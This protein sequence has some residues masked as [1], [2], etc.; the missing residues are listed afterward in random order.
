MTLGVFKDAILMKCETRG[1]QLGL[2]I[3]T[4]LFFTATL[5]IAYWMFGIAEAARHTLPEF[6]QRNNHG[7]YQNWRQRND[8]YHTMVMWY[9][10][11]GVVATILPVFVAVGVVNLVRLLTNT[12]LKDS[13][14]W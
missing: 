7:E 3:G 11:A 8:L 1:Q 5:G 14:T 9:A 10:L 12:G 2:V 6:A 13:D 4:A